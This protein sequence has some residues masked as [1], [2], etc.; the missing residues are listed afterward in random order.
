[1]Q[2]PGFS[3]RAKGKTSLKEASCSFPLLPTCNKNVSLG[4][5][6]PSGNHDT[7]N[8]RT[9][10]YR[11]RISELKHRKSLK[12]SLSCSSTPGILAIE[13]NITPSVSISITEAECNP[14]I[15]AISCFGLTS[16]YLLS[17]GT[18]T[19]VLFS[20]NQSCDSGKAT[21]SR[22]RGGCHPGLAN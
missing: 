8:S 2:V 20:R 22:S 5:E 7:I 13:V 1:M 12:P 10:A 4:L 19:L 15:V 14:N 3:S 6:Q 17:W 16:T 11:L 9:K 21:R 18:V